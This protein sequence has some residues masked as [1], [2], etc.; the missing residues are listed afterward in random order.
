MIGCPVCGCV[1]VAV[2]D[3]VVGKGVVSSRKKIGENVGMAA[4]GSQMDRGSP[5]KISAEDWDTVGQQG[6]YTVLLTHHRLKRQTWLE[7]SHYEDYSISF[8]NDFRISPLC[9]R[10]FFLSCLYYQGKL[11]SPAAD[12][13]SQCVPPALPALVEFYQE[14]GKQWEWYIT[15][16]IIITVS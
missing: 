15:V 13:H 1:A 6:G 14:R 16:M 2:C 5:L 7:T 9:V 10:L 3:W 11:L 12:A 8:T 4:R